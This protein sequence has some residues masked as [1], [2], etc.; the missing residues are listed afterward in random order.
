MVYLRGI[1]V[2]LVILLAESLHGTARRLW[3][4]PRLGDFPARQVS[5]FTGSLIIFTITFLFIRWIRASR[6]GQLIGLGLM[7]LVLT[8]GFEMALGRLVLGLSWERILSDYNVRQGGLMIFG[9][10]ILTLSP[11]LAARARKVI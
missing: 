11:L 1:A 10:L 6:I 4:E 2:W 8:V 5:V 7:W 9:L 3:L